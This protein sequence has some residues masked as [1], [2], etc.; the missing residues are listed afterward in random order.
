MLAIIASLG[1]LMLLGMLFLVKLF[2]PRHWVF[3]R[4]ERRFRLGIFYMMVLVAII[5]V[6]YSISFP[7]RELNSR[8]RLLLLFGGDIIFILL[9]PAVCSLH[10]YSLFGWLGMAFM[11]DVVVLGIIMPISIFI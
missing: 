5:A 2:A 3:R 4:P 10:P 7:F 8:P 6:D 1:L 9:V 11:L